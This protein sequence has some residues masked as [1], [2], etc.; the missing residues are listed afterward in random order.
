MEMPCVLIMEAKDEAGIIT[1]NWIVYDEIFPLIFL[2]NLHK[3]ME[4]IANFLSWRFYRDFLE[5]R[6]ELFR[7]EDYIETI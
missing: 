5:F 3:N 7:A 6:I 2:F 4:R 1:E